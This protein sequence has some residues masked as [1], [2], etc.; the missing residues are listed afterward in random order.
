MHN[1]TRQPRFRADDGRNGHGGLAGAKS[2]P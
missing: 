1:I 2:R